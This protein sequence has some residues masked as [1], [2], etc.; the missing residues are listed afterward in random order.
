MRRRFDGVEVRNFG[1]DDKSA[2]FREDIMVGDAGGDKSNSVNG[3]GRWGV[4]S[5]FS[6]HAF[7]PG[8]KEERLMT[9]GFGLLS[10]RVARSDDAS[11]CVPRGV[12]S[13]S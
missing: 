1:V 11:T 12:S 3:G 2:S 5:K 8:V 7:N 10:N 4:V 13:N 6:C 9:T